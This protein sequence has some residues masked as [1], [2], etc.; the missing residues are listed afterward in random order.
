M[1]RKSGGKGWRVR[2]RQAPAS[3]YCPARLPGKYRWRWSVSRPCSG[4]E[5]V[6]P[7]RSRHRGQPRASWR[8][9]GGERQMVLQRILGARQG[10][11]SG[12]L[13][14]SPWGGGEPLGHRNRSAAPVARLAPA[15]RP[16]RGLRG[17]LH[18]LGVGG[19]I[20]ERASRLDAVS[21]YHGRTTATRRCPWR[22][23]RSTGGPSAPVLSYWGR[24]SAAPRRPRRIETELSHDVLNPAR[25]P[26]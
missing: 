5:R 15:A 19:P 3:A 1:G 7:P 26:L 13:G 24:A 23:N 16:P 12:G 8:S 9:P 2:K 11:E 6:G 4:W 25:V 10:I 14:A 17:A 22:D 18:T 21:A 20:L